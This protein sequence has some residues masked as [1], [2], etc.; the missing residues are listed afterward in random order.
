MELFGKQVVLKSLSLPVGVQQD[1]EWYI[2]CTIK[3]QRT[4]VH[5]SFRHEALPFGGAS[6]LDT[7]L[8][9]PAG[10]LLD[11]DTR[12]DFFRHK[13]RKDASRS[14]LFFVVFHPAFYVVCRVSERPICCMI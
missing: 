13:K 2:S 10:I 14:L 12:I 1:K 3:C 4:M 11:G 9:I 7:Y 6:K 5:D 8:H